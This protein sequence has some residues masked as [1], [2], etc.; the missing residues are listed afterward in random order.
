MLGNFVKRCV[1]SLL[2]HA[3][4]HTSYLLFLE[5]RILIL[6]LLKLSLLQRLHKINVLESS[7]LFRLVSEAVLLDLVGIKWR[8]P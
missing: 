2:F 1:Q 6:Y 7:L 5:G 3:L 4:V 8:P